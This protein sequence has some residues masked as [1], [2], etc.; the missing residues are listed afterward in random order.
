MSARSSA[1]RSRR[2]R[3]R[4]F[5][6][7]PSPC[8]LETERPRGVAQPGRA[9]GLGPRGPQFKSV[10]PDH[11][12]DRRSSPRPHAGVRVA[13]LALRHMSN[14]S[15]RRGVPVGG[16]GWKCCPPTLSSRAPVADFEDRAVSPASAS[17]GLRGNR[18]VQT[19][20]DVSPSIPRRRPS[21]QCRAGMV[22]GPLVAAVRRCGR[23]GV[24]LRQAPWLAIQSQ[25]GEQLATSPPCAALN[26]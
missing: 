10:H 15:R 1:A 14:R 2:R 6:D 18:G 21:G 5:N 12:L 13:P 22:R 25:P 3:R 24:D 4:Q 20:C 23:G 9:L 7:A 8:T 11:F 26:P 16:A 19:A 17:R